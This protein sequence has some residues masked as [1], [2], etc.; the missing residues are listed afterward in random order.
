MATTQGPALRAKLF[1]SNGGAS[2]LASAVAAGQHSSEALRQATD[3]LAREQATSEAQ[4]NLY[5][6]K[7]G[8]AQVAV[9]KLEEAYV[10]QINANVNLQAKVKSD[11]KLLSQLNGMVTTATAQHREL[12]LAHDELAV[13][14]AEAGAERIALAA[15]FAQRADALAALQ[16]KYT[17]SCEH[18]KGLQCKLDEAAAACESLAQDLQRCLEDLEGKAKLQV[19]AQRRIVEL[20]TDVTALRSERE[21]LAQQLASSTEHGEALKQELA[22]KAIQLLDTE[23]VKA[24]L[25]GRLQEAKA[26]A[27]R[28]LAELESVQEAMKSCQEAHAAALEAKACELQAMAAQHAYE[29]DAK[30]AE[31]EAVVETKEGLEGEL[32]A[33]ACALEV[34]QGKVAEL[35]GTVQATQATQAGKVEELSTQLHAVN[36]QHAKELKALTDKHRRQQEADTERTAKKLEGTMAEMTKVRTELEQERSRAE[37]ATAAATEMAAD[38]A[39]AQESLAK[40]RA[41]LE[42]QVEGHKRQLEQA[43]AAAL[44]AAERERQAAEELAAAQGSG[45]KAQ[46][47]ADERAR[48]LEE[49][50]TQVAA[51]EAALNKLDKEHGAS[52]QKLDDLNENLRRSQERLAAAEA[53][54]QQLSTALSGKDRQLAERE[55]EL[56]GASQRIEALGADLTQK[57]NMLKGISQVAAH[58]AGSG[59][60]DKQAA[61]GGAQGGS[62]GEGRGRAA[63]RSR[64]PA[65][66]V[67]IQEPADLTATSEDE[68]SSEEEG[69]GEGQE[70]A[71]P[72]QALVPA[73]TA[74]NRQAARRSRRPASQRI[75]SQPQ[76]QR[77]ASL[78]PIIT[79]VDSGDEREDRR[80]REAE[81]QQAAAPAE[82]RR[83]PS[84]RQPAHAAV[85]VAGPAPVGHDEQE[86]EEEEARQTRGRKR[87]GRAAPSKLAV[88]GFKK[89]RGVLTSMQTTSQNVSTETGKR[90]SGRAN[91]TSGARKQMGMKGKKQKPAAAP[92]AVGAAMNLFGQEIFG[93]FGGYGGGYGFEGISP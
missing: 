16:A 43:A 89:P 47:Q 88:A 92:E 85:A 33:A 27:Q 18:G 39:A 60:S 87:S 72:G 7:L 56:A 37:A 57:T 69:E 82:E 73:G 19:E 4:V 21:G 65:K 15:A 13:Q 35:Q 58:V 41:G 67:S 55:A 71:N 70:E 14:L 66:K 28:L 64:R 26:E 22:S 81:A 42:A 76:Q 68:E 62:R 8:E 54:A 50:A 63:A 53:Q 34:L 48:Q 24:A 11:Y 20:V 12:K 25:E 93:A 80:E 1:G 6:T 74:G 36:Q 77:P 40:E 23:Q 9:K 84:Q 30:R 90:R 51:K 45:L 75:G 83:Q 49:L 91:A 3:K 79:E 31:L 2:G 46:E 59:G 38:Q 52:L 61:E 44:A 78:G 5:R 86:E 29:L 17:D 32:S 10:S